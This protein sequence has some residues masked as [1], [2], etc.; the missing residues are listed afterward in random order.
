L[1]TFILLHWPLSVLTGSVNAQ[2]LEKPKLSIG[3][4][5]KPL[6]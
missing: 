1:V 5:G 2:G 6:F 4:G 3:V